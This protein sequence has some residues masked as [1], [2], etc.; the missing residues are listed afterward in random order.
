MMLAYATAG[1]GVLGTRGLLTSA[2]SDCSGSEAEATR[3]R[4]RRA[5]TTASERSQAPQGQLATAAA[6]R[7]R[8]GS[9]RRP[10]RH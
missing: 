7:A 1:V 2:D 9:A 8:C 10:P 6:W 4:S 5:D 3:R